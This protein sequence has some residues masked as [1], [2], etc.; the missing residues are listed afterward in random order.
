[1]LN[2]TLII[3][4]SRLQHN[5]LSAAKR[6]CGNQIPYMHLVATLVVLHKTRLRHICN[7][8]VDDFRNAVI[9]ELEKISNRVVSREN[10]LISITLLKL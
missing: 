7:V 2:I 10:N 6:V 9:S 8:I 3:P 4:D 5:S 1:M